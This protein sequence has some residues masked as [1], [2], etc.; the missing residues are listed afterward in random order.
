M[1]YLIAY[2]PYTRAEENI[3]LIFCKTVKELLRVI[4]EKNRMCSCGI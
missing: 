3:K 1:R 4:V 2:V